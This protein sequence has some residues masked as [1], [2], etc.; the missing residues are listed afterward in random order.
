MTSNLT[1]TTQQDGKIAVSGNTY[2]VRETIKK[3]GGRWD[4]MRQ[5]WVLGPRQAK[6]LQIAVEALPEPAAKAARPVVRAA[7]VRPVVSSGGR[8]RARGCGASAVI[9]GYCRSCAHDEV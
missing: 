6:T 7:Y 9:G 8:C 3:A 5:V 4:P 1:Y 2:P